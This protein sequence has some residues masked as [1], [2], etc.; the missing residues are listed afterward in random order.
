[1]KKVPLSLKFNNCMNYLKNYTF[2]LI[3]ILIAL[4]GISLAATL[5]ITPSTGVY[6]SGSTFVARVVV[7]TQNKPINAAEGTIKFN[8]QEITVVSVD[9]SNSIFNLWVTEPTFSN[10]AGT[11]NFSGGL[12]SGYT[13]SSG[14]IFNIT[15]RTN[16]AATARVSITGGSVLANDGMGTNILSGMNGG[17]YTVQV[18]ST[19]PAP[20]IIEY[21]SP[22]NT[23]G[24]P[25]ITS[26]THPDN[27]KWY[28]ASKAELN[29]SLPSGTLAVRTLLDQS[30]Y[31]VPTK[32][33][34]DP[35]SAI[36]L[37]ELPE[38]VSYFHLQFKNAEGWGKVAHYRLAVDTQKPSSFTVTQPENYDVGNPVQVLLLNAAD[39]TSKVKRYM[40]K[41][42]NAEPYE[43]VDEKQSNEL[44]LGALE[45]GTHSVLVEAFDEAA[46][47]ISSTYTFTIQAF[48]KPIFT[49]Y[50]SEIN[51]EVIPVIKGLTR[52][53]A[54]VEVLIQ[55]IGAEPVQYSLTADDNGVFFF[56][57]EGTLS[58]GVYQLSATA[59]DEFAAKSEVSETI[60]IAVQQ[61][62]YI[63]VGSFLI[64]V[65]SVVIPLI[66]MTVLLV[67]AT[68]FTVAYL[69]RFRR[70][71]KVESTEV[72]AIVAKEFS[73]L[74]KTIKEK[75]LVISEARKTKRLTKMEEDTFAALEEDLMSA[76]RRIEKEVGDIEKLVQPNN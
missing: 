21:V 60:R 69:R 28:Q 62:G 7:N 74:H 44:I 49:D 35:I 42:D 5:S 75:Q 40:V 20:E 22:P 55:K 14:S 67:L 38:G 2:V 30:A 16:N 12:P 68:W 4:P 45:P 73:F 56:I 11:I 33:Y 51:E 47:S 1:M 10:T 64:N 29:W 9:R 34:E 32:V 61:P 70:K 31:S 39:A 18:V 76:Q 52:P 59:V 50:P 46:N 63:Q 6:S 54:L 72:V 53:R 15:F 23:P 41:V 71:I 57:P 27:T 24:L 43:F 37:D 3:L 48:D 65:L 19:S 8:P 36:S 66:A 25:S 26:T 58:M 17:T 13:G